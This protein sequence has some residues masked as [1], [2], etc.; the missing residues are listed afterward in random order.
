MKLHVNSPVYHKGQELEVMG[1]GTYPNGSTVELTDVQVDALRVQGFDVP[2]DGSDMY[3]YK[4]A[5]A[6]NNAEAKTNNLPGIEEIA[7]K[8]RAKTEKESSKSKPK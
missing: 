3:V 7:E 4:E 6:P 8:E 1:V 5:E 2:S